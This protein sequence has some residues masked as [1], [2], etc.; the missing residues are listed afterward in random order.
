MKGYHLL[1]VAFALESKFQSFCL[2]STRVDL[3]EQKCVWLGGSDKGIWFRS[4][5]TA[6]SRKLLPP[7]EKRVLWAVGR[8][9]KDH[10]AR[11]LGGA[12]FELRNCIRAGVGAAASEIKK[13]PLC[14]YMCVDGYCF[15]RLAGWR[16]N[17]GKGGWWLRHK[18]SLSV[19][20]GIFAAAA[21]GAAPHQTLK[22]T[23]GFARRHKR[24]SPF[25]MSSP[26]HY[27]KMSD[28]NSHNA[29]FEIN[30]PAAGFVFTPYFF[31]F[32][33]LVGAYLFS[34][35]EEPSAAWVRVFQ[36]RVQ[37]TLMW[38]RKTVLNFN[39]VYLTSFS[40]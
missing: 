7:R 34:Q 33:A 21:V 23:R 10:L 25:L 9:N 36:F 12:A 2:W 19:G 31:Q 40:V 24:A 20:G 6:P 22:R 32:F 17:L 8:V 35:F 13:Q 5:P 26:Y 29:L 28:A 38:T 39:S 3:H 16:N 11:S 18:R 4:R 27:L 30:A 14:L 1:S 37:I 15:S